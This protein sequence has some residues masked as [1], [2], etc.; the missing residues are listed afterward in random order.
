MILCLELINTQKNRIIACS[1]RKDPHLYI[2]ND[3]LPTRVEKL[4]LISHPDTLITNIIHTKENILVSL[5]NRIYKIGLNTKEKRVVCE[6][7]QSKIISNINIG[8]SEFGSVIAGCSEE[9][10][11]FYIECF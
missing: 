10:Q 7:K 3:T 6:I 8:N 11:F 2:I 5:N 9:K 1:I 4:K